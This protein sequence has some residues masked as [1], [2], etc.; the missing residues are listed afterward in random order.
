MQLHLTADTTI[1]EIQKEFHHFYSYLKIEFYS[2]PHKVG[3]LS[4]EK[5]R[6]AHDKK[7]SEVGKKGANGIYEWSADTT[8]R[9]FEKGLFEMCGLSVQVF[10]KSV[11]IWLETSIT[12]KW[13]LEKQ[14]QEAR[15]MVL[16]IEEALHPVIEEADF[17]R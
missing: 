7:I 14:N 5:Y 13:T 9:Y 17:E 12:D 10:R 3:E 2:E 16:A 4:R 1:A 6:I 11:N 8:V 15:L